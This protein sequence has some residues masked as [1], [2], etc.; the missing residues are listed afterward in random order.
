MRQSIQVIIFSRVT[1]LILG[2]IAL[3]S[4]WIGLSRAAE[5]HQYGGI[6]NFAIAAE[7][8]TYDAHRESS[9]AVIHPT[10]PHYSLL[11]K[12]DQE[13]YPKII[14]DIAESWTVSGDNKTYTFRIH[15]GVKFHDGSILSARDIKASYD[16]IIFPPPGIIS[17]RKALY[18]VVNKVDVLDDQ[19]VAF[20][21]HW[22][23]AAFLGS[24]ASPFNYIYKAE[25]L[26]KDP[27]WYE[28]NIMGTGPF[29]FVEHVAGSHWVGKRNEDYFR[30]GHP[31]LDGFR[32]TFITSSSARVAAV[33]S[34]RMHAEFRY[35]A[36]TD[37]DDLVR[38]LGDKIKVREISNITCGMVIFNCEKKPFDDPR[39]RRA[40]T[41]AINRW[42]GAKVLSKIIN[43][44]NVGGLLRP[45]SEFS[46]A[47]G[48]LT[49]VAGYWKDIEASRKEARRLLREAGIPEGFSFIYKNRPP[50][51]DYE[52]RAIWAID[53]WRQ[54]GVNVT[55]KPQEY[56]VHVK[57]MTSGNF[58]AIAHSISDY[59]DDPDLQFTRFISS[60]RSQFNYG[61][62][63][64]RVL[65]ALY[66]KQSRTMDPVERKK[67]CTQFEKRVL[68]E[69]AYVFVVPWTHRIV[70][71][72]SKMKGWN[73]L[74][75]H[76][77]NQDLGDVWLSKD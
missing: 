61:R 46:M 6:L 42:E 70:V 17:L 18:E 33:R 21:L 3:L 49:Q 44:K 8:P 10:A 57:D 23:S 72:S 32:A 58:E 37:R 77:L 68:D 74:P 62:Y 59:M 2:L 39:V 66:D 45:G 43:I 55:L 31:F 52:T 47:E 20:H 22:P 40:L 14:G 19:T 36:P 12:F 75:S 27:R 65:D 4:G 51:K 5:Q 16:K 54:I 1:G 64:D 15:K 53:Q 63:K 56:G 25:I 9:F 28:K 24:L 73:L 67:L 71:A 7:L 11:L 50:P 13:N 60:D 69:M 26:A 41:L 48:E 34:G 35:F 30:K 38:V 76:F 29:K